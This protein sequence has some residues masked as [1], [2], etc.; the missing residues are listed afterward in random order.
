MFFLSLALGGLLFVLIQHVTR[1]GWSVV[2]RRFAETT[3][4]ALPWLGILSLPIVVPVLAGWPAAIFKVFPWIDAQKVLSDTVLDGK[5]PFLNVPFFFLRMAVYF[6]LWTLIAGYFYRTSVRQDETGD[7]KLTEQMQGWS[8]P[9]I[10]IT[11]L[12]LTF[13]AVDLLM[14]LDPYWFSTIFGV[15]YFAGAFMGFM[16][17]TAITFLML[18]SAGRVQNV[19][20]TEHFHD[21]GKLMFAFTVFWAY[22]AFSQY[23]LIWY[24]NIPEE[25]SWIYARHHVNWRLMAYIALFGHFVLPFLLLITRVTKRAR[26]GLMFA[27]WWLLVMHWIDMAWQVW[28]QAHIPHGSMDV[29]LIT[30][31]QLHLLDV[32]HA[33]L[34][35]AGVGGVTFWAVISRMGQAALIPQRDPRLPMSLA[36]QNY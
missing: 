14:T 30:V 17:L 7:E 34:L 21:V 9:C 26:G 6:I 23:M 33:V 15:Y 2:V 11:A 3:A 22:I 5:Y 32:V 24:A 25:T 20:T 10:M 19:V 27:A 1:A 12:T 28:P 18:Q 31:S 4:M 16:S 13:C 29:S 36:F 8:A 35:L